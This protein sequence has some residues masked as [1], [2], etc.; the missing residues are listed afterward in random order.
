MIT[1]SIQVQQRLPQ[2]PTAVTVK[3]QITV[4]NIHSHRKVQDA[5]FLAKICTILASWHLNVD[6]FEMNQFHIS[7]AVHSRVSIIGLSKDQ[8]EDSGDQDLQNAI[9]DLGKYGEVEEK[10]NMATLTLVGLQ[11]KKSIGVAGRLF[12]A[13]GKANINIEMISQG[14][15][16]FIIGASRE[17]ANTLSRSE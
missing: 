11:L 3:H 9:I 12:S 1:P 16:P 14:E 7:I 13:L 2:K 10:H 8:R 17:C 15:I 6:L 4:V 5:D